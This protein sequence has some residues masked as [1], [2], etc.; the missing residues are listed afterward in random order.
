[1]IF[2]KKRNL[3]LT[4]I[5]IAGL[6]F[7]GLLGLTLG[8]GLAA[9][10]N[11]Q[12]MDSFGEYKPSIG[13]QILDIHG[14]LITE[15]FSDEKRELVSINDI[16]RSITDAL[17]TREDSEFFT[18]RGFSLRGTFRALFQALTFQFL[19]GGSTVTQQLA[20]HLY[21]DRRQKTI[22]RKLIEL[23]WALEIEAKLSK[24]EI[25]EQYLNKMPFGHNTY[26]VEAASR[27]YF[28]KSIKDITVAES[29]LL[30]IQLVKPGLYSPIKNPNGARKVQEEILNQMADAGLVTKQEAHDSLEAYWSSYDYGRDNTS[31]A[32]FDREDKAP[33]FSEYIRGEL[34]ENLLGAL[35]IYRDG[36]TVHTTL[37][38]NFQKLADEAM[39]KGIT[40]VNSKYRNNNDSRLDIVDTDIEPLL[41]MI[42]VTMN[43]TDFRVAGTQVNRDA[44]KYAIGELTPVIDISA[45]LFGLEP[46]SAAAAVANASI[47]SNLGRDNVEGALITLENSTG[48]IKAMVGGS[49]FDRANQFNRAVQAKVQP[50]SSFKPLFYSAAIDSRKFTPATMIYDGPV[51]FYNEDNTPYTPLNFKGEWKGTVLLREALAQSMNVPAIQVLAGVGFDAAIDRASKLLGITDPVEIANTFPRR[52]P[53]ALGVISVAPIK[54]ARAFAVFGNQGREVQPIAITYIQDRRGNIIA[55]PAADQLNDQRKR[56]SELQVV[57]PQNA[58]IMTDLLK[59]TVN[60]GTLAGAKESVGGFPMEMAGK[61]GTTQNWSDIWTVGYSPYYTTAVWFGFDKPGNSLGLSNTGATSA[62]PVWASY[63]KKIHRDLPA[64]NFPRPTTGLVNVVV[65]ARTGLLPSGEPDEPL[66]TEIFLDG[67]APTQISTLDAFKRERAEAILHNLNQNLQF[68]MQN[69]DE[70]NLDLNL[71]SGNGNQPAKPAAPDIDI[72]LD[73]GTNTTKPGDFNPLL[74]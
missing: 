47:M 34:D 21:A 28:K 40:E 8:L 73:G 51:V 4:I 53:L 63:M 56:A 20:G 3:V 17:V 30:V 42:A 6:S 64:K 19:S 10:H 61:T 67:T 65:D 16:P 12:K 69:P 9:T 66:L 39:A 57:S 18:H 13:S 54:M 32:F 44:R 72:N 2:S 60:S 27:F 22:T 11:I 43:V 25:M 26:G 52:Y 62:G 14:N 50:G 68:D 29:A 5:S 23:F 1:M 33:Y 15:F 55:N 7:A 45:K 37:D 24:R 59:T 49:Q 74:E 70:L 38:L 31:T 71:D 41:D 35:D 48:Y 36:F 58:Y 46:V